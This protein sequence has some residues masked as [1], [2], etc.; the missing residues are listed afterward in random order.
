MFLM[1]EDCARRSTAGQGSASKRWS[2]RE[3]QEYC[4]SLLHLDKYTLFHYVEMFKHS[5]SVKLKLKNILRTGITL[6]IVNHTYKCIQLCM[7][8]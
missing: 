2:R 6:R 7:Y 8:P 5:Q 4:Q 3:V 1:V